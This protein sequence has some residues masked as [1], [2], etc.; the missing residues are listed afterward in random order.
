MYKVP[1]GYYVIQTI[2][3]SK[4]KMFWGIPGKTLFCCADHE[5]T[6]PSGLQS[7]SQGPLSTSV[8][9]LA[10]GKAPPHNPEHLR[11]FSSVAA[12]PKRQDQQEPI[13]WDFN[14]SLSS[15]ETEPPTEQVRPLD[16]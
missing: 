13:I 10:R 3:L 9:T 12:C 1:T 14:K 6:I 5:V 4:M 11:S 8:A 15:L 2:S 7:R 16:F